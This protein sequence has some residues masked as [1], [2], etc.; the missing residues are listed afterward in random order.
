VKGLDTNVLLRFLIQDD[1]I[2]GQA[3]SAYLRRTCTA[4]DPG[5]VNRIALCEIVWVLESAYGYSRSAVADVIERILRTAEFL[6]ED[7]DLAHAA[8]TDYRRSNADFA[9][10]LMAKINRAHGCDG[11]ATFD[12][13]AAALDEFEL[14]SETSR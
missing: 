9:D 3:A 4:D 8:L 5:F 12:R 14:L 6:V 13:K 10:V 1:K 11:T 2:Q 7:K